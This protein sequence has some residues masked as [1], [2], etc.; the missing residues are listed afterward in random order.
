[1]P[2]QEKSK[3]NAE[4]YTQ[5]PKAADVSVRPAE[6]RTLNDGLKGAIDS[7]WEEGA[8]Q[9]TRRG[10]R[11]EDTR[12]SKK[13]DKPKKK[14][15]VKKIILWILLI[16]VLFIV[17]VVI[18]FVVL[19]KR[20]RKELT[21][22]NA[23]NT[24]I[25]TIDDAQSGDGGKTVIYKGQKYCYN[26]DITSILCMG[27]DQKSFNDTGTYQKGGQADTLFLMVIDTRTG[28]MTM[29]PISRYTMVTIDEYKKD[30]TY[31]RQNNIQVCLAYTYGDGREKSCEN[32]TTA[33]SRLMYGM[34][35]SSYLTIDMSAISSLNDAIGGV[36][37]QVL[38]DLSN[39]DP[40]LV[41]GANVTLM[42]QQ[43]E[44]YV[45]SRKSEG[46]DLA[47][48]NNAPR[49]ER[50]IQY[51]NNFMKKVLNQTKSNPTLPVSLFKQAKSYMITDVTVPEVTYLSGLLLQHG[52]DNSIVSIPGTAKKGEYTEVYPDDKALYEIILDVFYKKAD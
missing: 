19:Q 22:N 27:V 9:K 48:D 33:V 41:K 18:T 42:G 35:I 5:E 1:M 29:I 25:S 21:E 20:G 47:I 36:E 38:E 49:M 14:R 39:Q 44:T 7:Y 40:K 13:H 32:V 11:E 12:I 28:K 23:A 43:A 26:E 16:I 4:E 34:P 17:T 31:W 10:Y 8:T 37:V 24:E 15:S 46:P 2:R 51:M 45:R 3:Q 30:G 50:Q 52:L 6:D